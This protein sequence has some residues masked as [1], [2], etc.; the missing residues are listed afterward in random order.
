MWS[1]AAA[2][3]GPTPLLPG[4]GARRAYAH[5]MSTNDKDLEEEM[6]LAQAHGAFHLAAYQRRVIP[7]PGR[8][9]FPRRPGPADKGP[10]FP[11]LLAAYREKNAALAERLLLVCPLCAKVGPRTEFIWE[12]APQRAGQSAFGPWIMA[13]WTCKACN[14]AAGR[15]FESQTKDLPLS[16]MARLGLLDPRPHAFPGRM[17]VPRSPAQMLTDYKTALIIAFIVLGHLWVFSDP[18]E[19]IRRAVATGDLAALR[20]RAYMSLHAT[21]F[22]PAP[23]VRELPGADGFVAVHNGAGVAVVLPNTLNPHPPLLDGTRVE[24]VRTAPWPTFKQLG[25]RAV[26]DAC[27]AGQLFH[28]DLCMNEPHWAQLAA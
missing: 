27:G 18:V 25:H 28:F 16:A 9:P 26:H 14:W 7:R 6:L 12:H 22:G 10:Q 1:G 4:G 21:G 17:V 24:R 11:A 2:R 3:P 13:C 19:P 20:G 5:G 8:C 15:T 23:S